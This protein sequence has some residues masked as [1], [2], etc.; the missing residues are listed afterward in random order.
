[1]HYCSGCNKD[2]F[3]VWISIHSI[4]GRGGGLGGVHTPLTT[5]IARPLLSHIWPLP[6]KKHSQQPPKKIS[7]AAGHYFS[8]LPFLLK[9]L[10]PL[11]FS[12]QQLYIPPNFRLRRAVTFFLLP[13]YLKSWCPSHFSSSTYLNHQIFACG[14]QLLFSLF[15][16]YLNSLYISHFPSNSYIFHQIF[17][18]GGQ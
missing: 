15:P 4:G 18:C 3:L 17:A 7:P 5:K 14:R 10:V 11:T 12:L 9:Q 8:V 16:F 2:S 6:P 13:S 1:M